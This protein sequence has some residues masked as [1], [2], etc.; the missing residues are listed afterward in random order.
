MDVAIQYT[1]QHGGSVKIFIY[2]I[3][4]LSG[5]VLTLVLIG[6]SSLGCIF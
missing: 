3:F 2:F 1:R 4:V 6:V 5:R